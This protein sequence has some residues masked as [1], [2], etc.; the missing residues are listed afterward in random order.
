MT[1]PSLIKTALIGTDRSELPEETLIELKKYGIDI[2]ANSAKVL[3]EGATIFAQ[4]RKAGFQTKKWEGE[5]P[6][7]ALD[8]GA[9]ICSKKSSDHLTMILNGTYDQALDEFIQHLIQNKKS[10]PP[11][12]LPELFEKCKS[13]QVLWEKLRFAIGERGHWLMEQNEDW[14][15]LI[16]KAE[17]V[18]WEDG[19]KRERIALL[20][21]LR[22][23]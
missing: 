22:K 1:W 11:E 9:K 14:H 10:L 2:D 8:D 23:T 15:F 5:I 12:L 16:G 6:L 20:Q 3:L 4:M 13:D 21:H 17:H 18:A 19:T 7:P